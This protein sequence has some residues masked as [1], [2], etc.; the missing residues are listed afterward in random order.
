MF[1]LSAFADEYDADIH[2]QIEGL[3]RCGISLIEPRG[4]FGKNIAEISLDEAKQ[5]KAILDENDVGVSAI[6]SPIGKIAIDAPMAPELD[7]LRRVAQIAHI[8]DAKRIRMFSFFM[9]AK[10]AEANRSEVM[11]RMEQMIRVS[12][13][14]NIVLCHENE[15]GIYG[16]TPERNMDLWREMGGKL[17]L[18]YDPANFNDIGVQAYPHAYE[19]MKDAVEYF[20]IKD[21][22]GDCQF[23]PAGEGI[24]RIPELLEAITRDRAGKDVI[25]TLEP[26]LKVFDGMAGLE[27]DMSKIHAD[28]TAY[29]DCHV[30]FCAASRA[31]KKLIAKATD[32][33]R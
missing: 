25:L 14:E 9:E 17:A 4:L 11:R 28:Q 15:K 31:L 2:L 26:H 30:A 7:R 18:V 21:S 12:E 13:E 20:H 23:V 16:D 29:P 1:I 5:F 8:L 6:G 3:K 10:D 27:Q 22:R 32:E 24:G 19:V 33:K